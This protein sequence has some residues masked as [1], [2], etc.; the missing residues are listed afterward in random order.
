MAIGRDP[1]ADILCYPALARELISVRGGACA[2]L[3]LANEAKF[4]I[5]AGCLCFPPHDPAGILQLIPRW[6]PFVRVGLE[7][8]LHGYYQLDVILQIDV[9]HTQNP[10]TPR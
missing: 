6:E 2:S 3:F 5:L 4:F 1:A 8:G 7:V 10:M 9:V